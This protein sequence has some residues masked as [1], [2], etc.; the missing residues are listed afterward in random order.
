MTPIANVEMERSEE[1][2]RPSA[3]SPVASLAQGVQL[4]F[5]LAEDTPKAKATGDSSGD[6]HTSDASLPLSD[7][8]AQSSGETMK[9]EGKKEPSAKW[10][11]AAFHVICA[12]VGT[13]I[14]ALPKVCAVLGCTH[15]V[16][17]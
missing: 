6:G 17:L 16:T 7:S 14:L 10:Y 4:N 9:P 11:H 12:M 13:G 2:S 3:C 8:P 1:T 5:Y 15:L